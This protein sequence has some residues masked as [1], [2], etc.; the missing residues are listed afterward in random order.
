MSKYILIII[1]LAIASVG[2]AQ[3]SPIPSNFNIPEPIIDLFNT[4][5]GIRLNIDVSQVP[6]VQ[7]TIESVRNVALDPQGF[8]SDFGDWFDRANN[9]FSQNLGVPLTNI[10]QAIGNFF[11]WILELITRLIKLG[12]SYIN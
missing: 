12:L 10:L 8:T 9:W 6:L 4:F 1:G 2:F 3:E 7:S 11:I 5:R